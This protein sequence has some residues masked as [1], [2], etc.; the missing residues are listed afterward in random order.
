M[1]LIEEYIK[2]LGNYFE[3]IERFNDALIVKVLFPEKWGVYSSPDKRIKPAKS[4][5]NP[6]EYFYYGNSNDVK[7]EEIFQLIIETK[8]M[9]ESVVNKIKLLK[10]KIEEL[11]IFF[12]DKD[13]EEL[14]TLQFITKKIKKKKKNNSKKKKDK[15]DSGIDNENETTV[16]NDSKEIKEKEEITSVIYEEPNENNLDNTNNK[17]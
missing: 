5:N 11:K 15:P 9:N 14:E 6:Q 10:E 13:I 1:L 12:K 2:E 17:Q 3:G 16:E 8:K 4:E 7:L